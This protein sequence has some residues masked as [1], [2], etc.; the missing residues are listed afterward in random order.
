MQNRIPKFRQS[1]IISE[2]RGHLSEKLKIW[3]A[4]T[5]TEFSIFCWNFAYVSYLT[6]FTKGCLG[7]FY[8]LFRSWIRKKSKNECVENQEFFNFYK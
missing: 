3:R 7:F 4:L 1:S 6:I 5:T 2:K 8:I